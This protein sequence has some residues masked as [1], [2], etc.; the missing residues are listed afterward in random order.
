MCKINDPLKVEINDQ[1]R[2]ALSYALGW[3][4]ETLK[5]MKKKPTGLKKSFT[6]LQSLQK[7][8]QAAIEAKD[9]ARRKWLEDADQLLSKKEYVF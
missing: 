8:I 6:G 5:G 4:G 3:I 1:D 9:E 7:K 2:E